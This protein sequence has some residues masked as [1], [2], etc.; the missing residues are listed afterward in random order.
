MKN[1]LGGFPNRF[2]ASEE[3][4]KGCELEKRSIKF[5]EC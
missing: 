2:G 3:R 4:G 1:S 5:V